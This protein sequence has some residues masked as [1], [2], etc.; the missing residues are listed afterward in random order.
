VQPELISA[1]SAQQQLPLSTSIPDVAAVQPTQAQA[2][3]RQSAT[4]QQ[5]QQAGA[6]KVTT[7]TGQ[8]ANRTRPPSD[9][10]AVPG[11]ATRSA[12]VTV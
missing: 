5:Q 11:N 2:V 6:A 1:P 4:S 12:A 8:T 3:A 7:A 10:S 9:T